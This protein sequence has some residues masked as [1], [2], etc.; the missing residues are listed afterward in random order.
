MDISSSNITKQKLIIIREQITIRKKALD[1]KINIPF[2]VH[3]L[4]RILLDHM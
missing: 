4:C 1:Q 2:S 3:D